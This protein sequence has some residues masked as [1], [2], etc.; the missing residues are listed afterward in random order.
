[1]SLLDAIPDGLD[2]PARRRA[3][4]RFALGMS[5]QE[6]QELHARLD[7]G[8]IDERHDG[9]FVA[10]VRRDVAAVERALGDG[11]LRGRALSAAIRL[12]V[13]DAALRRLALTT[14]FATRRQVYRVLRRSARRGLAGSLLPEV[15]ERDRPLLLAA[16]AAGVVERW[17]PAL[18]V[19]IDDL[20]R[21]ARTAPVAVARRLAEDGHTDGRRRWSP[22]RAGV[23]AAVRRDP[24]AA[25]IVAEGQRWQDRG[26]PDAV[27]AALRAGQFWS[28]EPRPHGTGQ[29]PRRA[30][31]TVRALPATD[32]AGLARLTDG[33]GR[34]ALLDAL[35]PARRRAALEA[36]PLDNQA[37]TPELCVLP[38][39]DRVAVARDRLARRPEDPEM[40]AL[41]P[42]AEVRDTLLALTRSHRAGQREAGWPA[43]LRSAML[44]PDRTAFADAIGRA[45]RA[46]TDQHD[47]Q[48]KVLD[49]L[50]AAPARSVDAVPVPLV[51]AVVHATLT[52]PDGAPRS[53]QHLDDWLG[54]TLA[55]AL[56]AANRPDA[57]AAAVDRAA[58][59]FLQ[60]AR[61]V[62]GLG[63]WYD[64]PRLRPPVRAAVS[65]IAGRRDLDDRALLGVAAQLGPD[66]DALP[67]LRDRLHGIVLHGADAESVREAA[68]LWVGGA[69]A[70]RAE[71][72][73]T[74]LRHDPALAREP[75]I[76][77]LLTTRH[78]DLLDLPEVRSLRPLVP[79]TPAALRAWRPAQ[80]RWYRQAA[81]EQ[82][83]DPAAE[84]ADR[85][86]AIRVLDDPD[87]LAG[88]AGSDEGRIA[89]A[90]LSAMA[91]LPHGF[92]RLADRVDDPVGYRARAAA[93]ALRA[94]LDTVTEAAAVGLLAGTLRSAKVASA[95]ESA[96]ALG[97]LRTPAA[98]GALLDAWHRPD[99]HRDVRATIATALVTSAA[100][101]AGRTVADVL[102]A[103]VRPGAEPD[104]VREAILAT[105]V[106]R[107]PVDRRPAVARLLAAALDT[108][109]PAILA[110]YGR[111]SRYAPEGLDAVARLVGVDQPGEVFEAARATLGAALG[112]P[113]GDLAWSAAVDLLAAQAARERLRVMTAAV[114][115]DAWSVL[116]A[117]FRAAAH[118]LERALAPLDLPGVRATLLAR[119]AFAGLLDQPAGDPDL[120][121]WDRLLAATADRPHRID[122]DTWRAL[123]DHAD[124]TRF[125]AVLTHLERHTGLTATLLWL[126]LATIQGTWTEPQLHRLDTLRHHPDP[127]IREAAH[128]VRPAH[129]D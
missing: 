54:R 1:M 119:L 17:L 118:T 108:P 56:A 106:E 77:R 18:P 73:R 23:E 39:A 27:A 12:P 25:A 80:R 74:L 42:Y 97:A 87:L 7:G 86:A 60:Y 11:E 32:L 45:G 28:V 71:R 101:D 104:A 24:A 102:T 113:A 81:A 88:L 30:R 95:K 75:E 83:T 72:V 100:A 98:T 116:P 46:W 84:P 31:R 2:A 58:E 69:P 6:Y 44:D 109:D 47:V 63:R 115:R 29:L 14:P 122:L 64:A 22:G 120:A 40:L 20:R 82:A 123:H 19:T 85:I 111:W 91:R 33:D 51:A 126:R 105:P 129:R 67:G 13:S 65:Y 124:P 49:R 5:Q 55:V 92:A 117:A 36:W 26:T 53:R 9:L 125:P 107:I 66:L 89:V 10:V 57:G 110:A 52:R 15:P 38:F 90:A 94:A 112:T 127:D 121:L 68:R 93:R 50:A 43:L 96:R 41:L 61:T 103:A 34:A 37:F 78:T 21:L 3:I 79:A 62:R 114:Q 128:D 4:A 8:D 48:Q 70:D 59:V 99:L 35:P 16:C 76:A